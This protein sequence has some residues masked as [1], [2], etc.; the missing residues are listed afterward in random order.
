MKFPLSLS[1]LLACL[2]F[3]QTAAAQR[4]SSEL[5]VVEERLLAAV[6]QNWSDWKHS[7]GTPIEGST[8]VAL[9][10]WISNDVGVGVTIVR[11]LTDDEAKNHIRRFS[12]DMHF[13]PASQDDSDEAYVRSSRTGS[14]VLRKRNILFYIDVNCRSSIDESELVRQMRKL[15]SKAVK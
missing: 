7:E 13:S 9:H 1:L 2:L 5:T 12:H 4:K 6:G 15:A 11:Y 3:A 8:D 14:L 10:R